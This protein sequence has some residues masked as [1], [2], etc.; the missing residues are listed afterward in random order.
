MQRIRADRLEDVEAEVARLKR[1][2]VLDT[3]VIRFT[4]RVMGNR[5][6]QQDPTPLEIAHFQVLWG[7]ALEIKRLYQKTHYVFI[8][9]QAAQF[10]VWPY[11]YKEMHRSSDRPFHSFKPL[12][13]E[14]CCVPAR[15]CTE[16]PQAKSAVFKRLQ[17]GEHDH[18]QRNVLLSVD[19]YFS[20]Q[21][22]GESCAIFTVNN[23]SI[24]MKDEAG[25]N[26][27]HDSRKRY[28]RR[29]VSDEQVADGYCTRLAVQEAL[30][31]RESSCGNIVVIAVKKALLQNDNTNFAYLSHPFGQPCHCDSRKLRTSDRLDELQ[32]GTL[33]R[34]DRSWVGDNIIP[35]VRLHTDFLTPE[36]C[37]IFLLTSVP[38]AVKKAIKVELR[39]IAAELHKHA[40]ESRASGAQVERKT[41]DR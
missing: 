1:S 33:R 7:R 21:Q 10:L 9:G 36:N 12:R 5:G 32:N 28:L 23:R 24:I 31:Q 8:H 20:N 27:L 35:Q 22:I 16:A 25:T 13:E 19:A 4:T 14:S 34:C 40:G 17:K 26:A 3:D 39:T 15:S 41:S 29:Y 6:G 18:F 11:F 38:K 2:G 30:A 37:D